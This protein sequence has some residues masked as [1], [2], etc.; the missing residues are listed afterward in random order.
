MNN[1]YLAID[2]GASS[3]RHILA[4][5]NNGVLELE[6]VY[7]FQNGIHDNDGWL[8][9]DAELLLEEILTGMKRCKEIGKQPVAVG[10]DTWGVDFVL[11]D[12]DGNRLGD[13]VSYRD[14]RTDGM[15]EKVHN[16]IDDNEL[17]QRTG[18][19]SQ[20][21]NTIY[22][23]MAI[24]ETDASLLEQADCMLMTPDYFN[25]CLTGLKRQEYTMATTTQ[26]LCAD[27][28]TWDYELIQSLGL[29]SKLFL[30]IEVPGTTLGSLTAYVQERIGYNCQVIMTASHDTASAIAAI[31][32]SKEDVLYIS[33]GTWSLM[34]IESFSP[35][36]SL[37]A[38]QSGCSN[39]G[40]YGQTYTF[41]KNIMGLWMIQSVQREIGEG[42]SFAEICKLASSERIAS[43]VDCNDA[44]FLAPKSMV[45]AIQTYCRNTEQE[46][47]ETLGA[48]AAVIYRSLA[49]CYAQTKQELEQ[50][51]NHTYDCI[52]I[53]GGG[54]QASY[55][56][57]LTSQIASCDV[58]AGP[59]E[60]TAIGNLLIQMVAMQE[61]ENK[62]EA[63]QLVLRTCP[64][65]YLRLQS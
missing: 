20:C 12:V 7:R 4:R 17:Y 52:Y 13:F 62:E 1:Y 46:V 60:A 5:K 45:E 64:P 10:I 55:L 6:E 42:K 3:G 28:K 22:Q 30:P 36:C 44:M 9:W 43:L 23:L 8:C 24:K 48:V 47:P 21:Y 57:E 32:T 40:G 18:I 25:Y 31:P 56:N 19:Q 49:N 63:R 59:A 39:E 53:I 11:L 14:A 65:T 15:I 37:E 26:L 33:S 54:S 38:M 61:I 41:L 27:T 51:K 16:I 58:C 50:L 34:G 29:P 2:I 35:V